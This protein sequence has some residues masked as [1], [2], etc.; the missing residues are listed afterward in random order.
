MERKPRISRLAAIA[1]S[2]TLLVSPTLGTKAETFIKQ[3]AG[4]AIETDV[5][6]TIIP[7]VKD[8][9]AANG[10]YTITLIT[11]DVVKV[12]DLG[13]GKSTIE[14]T[15]ADGV[16]DQTRILTVDGETYVFPETAMT[17]IA[18]GQLDD[19]LFNITK[20]IKNGYTDSEVSSLPLIVE[21]KSE[22]TARTLAVQPK[23]I[24][25]SKRTRTLESID[26]AAVSAEK[27]K[28]KQFWKS[29]SADLG[30]KE[31]KVF[32]Q[33]Q[34]GI[35]KIWLDGKVEATLDQSV[36]QVGA[37]IAWGAGYDGT[38]TT[39]AVLDSGIDSGHPDVAGQIKDIKNF[40]PGE[41]I[42]DYNSHGTHV[43]STVLG[44]G[45]AS[46]GKMKGVAPGA[47][48]IVGKV[49]A[50][51]GSGLNSWIIDGMEWAA[52]HADVVTMSLGSPDASDGKDPVSQALNEL[53]EE[54]GTLFVVAAGNRGG[55]STIGYPGAAD[56][57]LTVGA[58]S[59]T[60][61]LASF[62]SRGPRLGDKAI[63]PDMAAPGVGIVAARSQFAKG[64]GMYTSKDGT[65]MAT[66]HVAGAAAILKQKY[67]TW[68]GKQI[69]DALVSTTKQ[70][71]NYKPSEVGSGR[72]D[73]PAALNGVYATGSIH[74][75]FFDWP[76]DE[77]E[78]IEKTITYHNDRDEAVTLDLGVNFKDASG[79]P[80][81]AGLLKLS[82]N[83]ITVPA[84]GQASVKVSADVK[85]GL[86][87]AQYN[88]YVTATEEGRNT[89]HTTLS[90]IK[91]EERY[92]LTLKAYDRDGSEILARALIY[93]PDWG[94]QYVNVKG[95]AELRLPPGNYSVTAGL[96]V[97]ANTD[98]MGIALVGDPEVE[99]NKNRTVELDA[100]KAEEVK[101][102]APKKTEPI[103]RN[104]KFSR[105]FGN[106]GIGDQWLLPS[107][108]DKMYVQPFEQPEK[109]EFR[110]A[111]RQ[112]LVKPVLEINFKGK[113]LDDLMQHGST[114]LKGN[115][116]LKTVYAGKG[117]PADYEKIDAKGK[118]VIIE[119]SDEVD[120]YDRGQ[121][122][123]QAGAKLLLVV[124][125]KETELVESY[126]N[127]NISYDPIPL[128]VTSLNSTDGKE[129][130]DAVQS[131]NFN[132]PVQGSGF[133]PYLYDLNKVYKNSI[134]SKELVYAPT[135]D[136]LAKI[137]T[138]YHSDRYAT[139]DEWRFELQNGLDRRLRWEPMAFPIE[140]E[141]WVTPEDSEWYQK[142]VTSDDAWEVRHEPTKYKAGDRLEHSYFAPVVRPGFGKS[143]F[144]PYRENKLFYFNVPAWGD[145]EDSHTGFL[146]QSRL[147][148]TTTM[149]L[150]Q[151]SKLLDQKLGTGLHTNKNYTFDRTQ[152]RLVADS[153][154]NE[155]RWSTST[156]THTEWTFWSDWK[157]SYG[158]RT[159]VPLMEIDY[160][161]KTNLAGEVAA[162]S[163]SDLVLTPSHIPGAL[164]AGNI[165]GAALDVS[166]D[167]GTTWKK[168]ELEREGSQWIAK[169]KHPFKPGGSV[170]LRASAWDDAE[171]KIEQEIMKA[172]RLR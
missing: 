64:T 43:A 11:G 162:G 161:V 24:A 96:N 125:D 114:P 149:K 67:P 129:L 78:A 49:L 70:L 106:A 144:Y 15:P 30:T 132:L 86:A 152:Y 122:A 143:H 41:T 163:T 65:S 8:V 51:N 34:Q 45:A 99:L 158:F 12:T 33:L 81:P 62:S 98:H 142:I 82:A 137:D 135:T 167:E 160:D 39:V 27:G 155:E 126:L 22:K 83:K 166:F 21:Y 157:E 73:V 55:Q 94:Y 103:Y 138:K 102:E 80:A 104:M 140:R 53:S 92:N 89:A 79:N 147:L 29:I 44:T 77:T 19:D 121:A 130:I 26:G 93:S 18:E 16:E 20:L 60:D 46:A 42:D 105:T 156:N 116:S 124:N 136:E 75:G 69:K 151:G 123:I 172:Y 97:D 150:Y 3:A 169:I 48:L 117:S 35:E 153:F 23:D 85:L 148:H 118:A 170:S 91:E 131:G 107:T 57:A 141:E 25:G 32:P 154:R 139:G 113:I 2:T 13:D 58:V 133:A 17:Y 72:L 76:H 14:V 127:A 1:L 6:Q 159:T 108:A 101:F 10:E 66:P 109:G 56:Q 74:F 134:S 38:G 128:A 112:R 164:G 120:S 52:T 115:F 95:T 47:D 90:L 119:R 68:T 171:N 50:N 31:Q 71:Q 168:V 7:T 146:D 84:K 165:E 5:E 110:F 4:S 87:G 9:P 28:A 111:T 37:P 100:R 54:T 36:P 61:Q 145:S 63:K 59:K 88:G 40:V